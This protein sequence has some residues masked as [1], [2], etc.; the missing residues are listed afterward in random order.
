[1]AE[2]FQPLSVSKLD[3]DYDEFGVRGAKL[4][5]IELTQYRDFADYLAYLNGDK[6]V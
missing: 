3:N 5:Q 2:K 6:L 1:M 4:T